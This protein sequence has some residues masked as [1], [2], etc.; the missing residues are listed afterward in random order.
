MEYIYVDKINI[1]VDSIVNIDNEEFINNM[2]IHL[3]KYRTKYNIEHEI[4]INKF[5]YAYIEKY[6]SDYGIKD[7]PKLLT[8]LIIVSDNTIHFNIGNDTSYKKCEKS[9]IV[10]FPSEWFISFKLDHPLVYIGNAY[11]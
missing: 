10:I 7:K 4:Y 5:N 3:N 8:C 11:I 2:T 9:S 6:T 1:D